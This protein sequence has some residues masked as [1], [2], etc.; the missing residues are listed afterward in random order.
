[1]FTVRDGQH[2]ILWISWVA[3][4]VRQ[5]EEGAGKLTT[6][7]DFREEVGAVSE[8]GSLKDLRDLEG[9]RAAVRG[10]NTAESPDVRGTEN[11]TGTGDTENG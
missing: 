7:A 3:H 10:A 8:R 4:L 6:E 2:P 9:W 5:G 1:M 11:V